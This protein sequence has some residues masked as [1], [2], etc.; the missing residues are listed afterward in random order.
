MIN[1]NKVYC[2]FCDKETGNDKITNMDITTDNRDSIYNQ[3]DN[4]QLCNSCYR[5]FIKYLNSRIKNIGEFKR[6]RRGL[7]KG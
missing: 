7:Y 1:N 5:D 2:D 6:V 3:Y 4:M